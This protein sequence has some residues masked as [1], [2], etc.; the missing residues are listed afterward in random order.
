[1]QASPTAANKL[2]P[3]K[4]ELTSTIELRDGGKMP[5]FGLGTWR[6]ESGGECREACDAA[7]AMGYN[8]LD[9]ASGYNNEEDVGAAITASGRA[10]EDI[11]VVTKHSGDHGHAETLAACEE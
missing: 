5:I 2:S 11:Y 1:V 4:L 7:L 6:A 10:R 3:G 8:L 9:T